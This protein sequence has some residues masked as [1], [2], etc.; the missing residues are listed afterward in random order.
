MTEKIKLVA[1][2][3]EAGMGPLAGPALFGIAI[4]PEGVRLDGVRDSKKLTDEQ[5]YAAAVSVMASATFWATAY[6]SVEEIDQYGVGQVW[7]EGMMR[8]ACLGLRRQMVDRVVVDGN[9]KISA[10]ADM[11]EWLGRPFTAEYI[12]KADSKVPAVSAA[13]V[14]AKCEQLEHMELL[15][16]KYPEYG[17]GG[18]KGHHGYGTE[19]H[20]VAIEEHGAVPGVHRRKYVETLAAHRG[21]ELR[22][23]NL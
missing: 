1:G 23:R 22:W 14:M 3:D 2:L 9:R 17:F 6:F 4:L 20:S 10:L 18:P 16:S 13:S 15:H 7:Q 19:A 12:V 21:F 11:R 8:V 5:K